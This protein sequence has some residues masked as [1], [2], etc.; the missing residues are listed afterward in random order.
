MS[1]RAERTLGHGHREKEALLDLREEEEEERERQTQ[2][3][4]ARLCDL[5]LATYLSGPSPIN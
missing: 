5:E 4:S 1:G 3:C 2:F